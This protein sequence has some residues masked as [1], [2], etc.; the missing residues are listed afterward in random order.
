LF[1]D[2]LLRGSELGSS[3]ASLFVEPG[4]FF[5]LPRCALGPFSGSFRLGLRSSFGCL[6]LLGGTMPDLRARFAARTRKVTVPRPLQI[7]PGVQNGD[8]LR[9]LRSRLIVHSLRLLRVHPLL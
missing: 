9:G 7:S 2:N 6:G 8:I 5:R 3:R 1:P 4:D